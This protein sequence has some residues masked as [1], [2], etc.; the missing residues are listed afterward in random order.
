MLKIDIHTHIIPE[1]LPDYSKK[2]GYDVSASD[3]HMLSGSY[4]MLASEVYDQLVNTT[5]K[6]FN[7]TAAH[8]LVPNYFSTLSP[9]TPIT[10]SSPEAQQVAQSVS[11]TTST[12][13]PSG[14]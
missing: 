5:K 11:T 2:F 3:A 7:R 13:T 4:E 6:V 9:I 12:T 1:K 14:Y 8:P 10:G